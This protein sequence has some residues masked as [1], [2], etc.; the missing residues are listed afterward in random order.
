MLDH[1]ES[2]GLPPIQ[3]Y[4]GDV[5]QNTVKDT[6]ETASEIFKKYVLKNPKIWILS[7]ACMFIY[8]VR[9]GLGD[10]GVTYLS[11]V[12]TSSIGWASLK[13]S[14]LK[15][16]GIPGTIIAGYIADKYFSRRNLVVAIIYLIGM[17]C[18]IIL[19]YYIPKG[20]GV[21]D[22]ISFGL[23]GFFIYGAQMVC[24]GLAPLSMVPRRAVA[25]AVGLTGAMSYLGAVLTSTFSGW[26]TDQMGWSMTFGFWATCALVSIFILLIWP[27]IVEHDL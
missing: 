10:W 17:C 5:P 12:K 23:S 21:W 4:H 9:Y 2:V 8:M 14:F 6:D 3:E 25:S 15:L 1:P 22:G 26:I 16:M 19:I 27:E 7:F 11:E 20:H 13:S 24:T 18:T